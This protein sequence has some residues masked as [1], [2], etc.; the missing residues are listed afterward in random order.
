MSEKVYVK[1]NE[2]REL[3][4]NGLRYIGFVKEDEKIGEIT[5]DLIIQVRMY[6][7]QKD[8]EWYKGK[9]EEA[10][11]F[12][13]GETRKNGDS[14]YSDDGI[15]YYFDK[16]MYL[17]KCELYI[18]A[19]TSSEAIE[20][21]SPIM[22]SFHLSKVKNKDYYE[23][24]YINEIDHFFTYCINNCILKKGFAPQEKG[25]KYIRD[26]IIECVES[27]ETK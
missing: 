26:R 24:Y 15:K 3:I 22:F 23:Y 10:F 1:K 13:I 8:A 17:E 6:L 4:E 5:V 12:D 2:L 27:Q 14:Y 25:I 9:F 7:L 19:K 16:E 11:K 21:S 18:N 20:F